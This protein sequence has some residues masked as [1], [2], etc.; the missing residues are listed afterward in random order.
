MDESILGVGSLNPGKIG[1]INGVDNPLKGSTD[2]SN[3]PGTHGPMQSL[4]YTNER[5]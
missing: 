3:P 1:W 5:S 2:P 4:T